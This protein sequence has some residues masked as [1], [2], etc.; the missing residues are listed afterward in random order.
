M[1]TEKSFK[2]LTVLVIILILAL[3]T[4]FI[5]KPI[6]VSVI[7]GLIL[8]YIFYPLYK[9]ML[10]TIKNKNLSA[11]LIV[12]F[13]V[14][15]I[16]IPIWLLLPSTVKQVSNAYE[17]FQKADIFKVL[18]K[19]APS[20]FLASKDFGVLINTFISKIASVLFT[21]L[22]GL[23]LNFTD[24]LLKTVVVLLVLFFSLRDQD[25]LKD[26]AKRLSP[27]SPAL[28]K[29]IENKFHDITRS[30][31]YGQVLVGIIQGIMAGLGL[32][33]FGVPN[34]L[35]LMM[36][37]I[38]LAVLPLVGAWL[39]WFPAVLY[40]FA[41]GKTGAGIG[42]L[43]YGTF[44]V[45][46]ADNLLRTFIVSRNSNTSPVVIFVGMIGGLF[47]FGLIGLILGPLIF[48]YFIILLEIFRE[49][50]FFHLLSSEA[51]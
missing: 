13:L 7:W 8:S 39:V 36:F 43:V 30:V 20:Q 41:T 15:L 42:L 27:F 10:K 35:L 50:K 11:G 25:S 44:F 3:V 17:F 33:I 1:I 22:E 32:F 2:K 37:T 46:L 51:V 9:S 26:Y 34:A 4:L 45:S 48:S 19:I 23:F 40:L 21:Q 29:Q 14:V 6:F 5:I 31:L 47:A 28:E 18:E 12:F 38:L 16:F 49:K 24:I